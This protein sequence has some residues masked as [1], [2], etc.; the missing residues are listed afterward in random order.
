MNIDSYEFPEDL[1]YEKNHF[2]GK[3]LEDGNILFGATDY[4]QKIYIFPSSRIF[5][6]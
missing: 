3:I 4:F 1:Y 5:P 2:L 6:K